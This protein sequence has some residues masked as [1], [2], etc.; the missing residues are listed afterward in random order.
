VFL[1][2]VQIRGLSAFC[3]QHKIAIIRKI[4]VFASNL[5]NCSGSHTLVASGWPLPAP[6]PPVQPSAVRWGCAPVKPY[7]SRC[8]QIQFTPL[9]VITAPNSLWSLLRSD[10]TRLNWPVA[11]SRAYSWVWSDWIGRCDQSL[12]SILLKAMLKRTYL[13]LH[14]SPIAGQ[15]V[16]RKSMFHFISFHFICLQH[17]KKLR[18]W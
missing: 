2:C 11:S 8:E 16:S 10:S 9:I 12:T 5:K 4:H 18:K 1:I 7:R 3:S 15:S 13:P 14:S 6:P 17:T